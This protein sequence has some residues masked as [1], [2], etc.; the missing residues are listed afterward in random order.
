MFKKV[1]ILSLFCFPLFSE[2]LVTENFKDRIRV[3]YLSSKLPFHNYLQIDFFERQTNLRFIYL[4]NSSPGKVLE[5]ETSQITDGILW[6]NSPYPEEKRIKYLKE[7]LERKNFDFIILEN[8]RFNEDIE[9]LIVDY[10]KDGGRLIWLGS[11]YVKD[12]YLSQLCPYEEAKLER[13]K[14]DIKVVNKNPIIIGIPV[15]KIFQKINFSPSKFKKNVN[16][17]ILTAPSG[18]GV[19]GEMEFGKGKIVVLNIPSIIPPDHKLKYQDFDTEF[20][21]CKFW[22]QIGKFLKYKNVYPYPVQVEIVKTE[23]KEILAGEDIFLKIKFYEYEKNFSGFFVLS[24]IDYKNSTYYKKEFQIKEVKDFNFKVPE[25]IESGIYYLKGEILNRK[26]EKVFEAYNLLNV[27][28]NVKV[29]V[30]TDKY[31]YEIGEEV[32]IKTN[33]TSIIKPE[34]YKLQIV[35]Y[36]AMDIPVYFQEK[37]ILN[38]E[39]NY[40]FKWKMP[41]YGVD[42]WN[43]NICAFVK[44]EN[45]D[46]LAS[47]IK[48]FWRYKK[49][50]MRE[51]FLFSNYWAWQDVVPSSMMKLFALYH[52]GIGFNGG[53]AWREPYYSYFNMRAW[54][55]FPT[56]LLENFTGN[57]TKTDFSHVEEWAKKDYEHFLHTSAYVIYDFGEESGFYYHWSNNP[58]GRKWIKDED[59]PEGAHKLFQYYLKEK[60]KTIEKLNE[61]WETNFKSFEEVKLKRKYGLPS[62]WLFMPLKEIERNIAPYIDT[63]GFFF[64]YN[65][66]VAENITRNINKYNPTADWSLSFQLTFNLYSPIPMTFIHPVYHSTI[67][68]PW[69]ARAIQN[70]LNK[71]TPFFSFHWGFDEIYPVWGQFWNHNLA[72]LSTFQCNWGE[73]FNYNLTHSRSTILFKNYVK[74][75]REREKFFLNCYPVYDY[76]IGIYHPM[77]DWCQVYSRPEF[78][79][80]SQG[81]DSE[82]M[83]QLGYKSTGAGFLGGPEFQIYNVLSSSGY[84]PVFVSDEEILKCKIILIPYCELISKEAIKQ[85]KEF[86]SNGGIL[87]TF[88]VIGKYDEYGKPYNKIPGG[89]LDEIIGLEL[90]DG[91]IGQRTVITLPSKIEL[92]DKIYY[93]DYT[94]RPGSEPPYLWIFAHQNVKNIYNDTKVITKIY[95]GNPFLTVHQYGKG[96]A[97]HINGFTFDHFMQYEF[98]H[99][100]NESLRQFLTS[101]IRVIGN[102]NPEI[103]V[104]RPLYY[105]EG[106]PELV[107]YQYKLEQSDI[108]VLSIYS[109]R[110]NQEITGEVIV[111]IPCEE[112]IDIL[113]GESISLSRFKYKK[114]VKLKDPFSFEEKETYVS[115]EGWSFP[116]K[117]S[118]GDVAFYA[119]IPY[120][121]GEINLKLNSSKIVV[122]KDKISI[123]IEI[124][125]KDK[126]P[127]PD[128]HPVH[129]DVFDSSGN[130]MPML[131]RKITCTS[132]EKIEIQTRLGDPSGKWKIRVRDCLNGKED[133]KEVVAISQNNRDIPKSKEIFSSLCPIKKI[134]ISDEEF[135]SLL[136]ALKNL[137]LCKN[138][139]K[140]DLSFYVMEKDA[141]RNR[142]FQLL[143]QVNWL[144]KENVLKEYLKRGG[145]IILTGEDLGYECESGIYLDPINLK[146]Y[147]EG[148]DFSV[149]PGLKP[150]GGPNKLET[151]EKIL[152]QKIKIPLKVRIVKKIGKG[153]II[154]DPISFDNLTQLSGSLY[155]YFHNKWLEDLNSCSEFKE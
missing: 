99:F 60:Y 111:N 134:D 53:H 38:K 119:L 131:S 107:Y 112:V 66:Q 67:L 90:E 27:K 93:L 62:G 75:V 105:G 50:T 47:D 24:L 34:N 58:F 154:L 121:T 118:P 25:N 48:W 136:N 144:E 33:I 68:K 45:N 17:I 1:I 96:L 100:Q 51:K 140:E 150:L 85:L 36:D 46:L 153:K 21:L 10:V 155:N 5:S 106:I 26:R 89:G 110:T 133:I 6:D 20:L 42:G 49:W 63:H 94:E 101:I 11:D 83:G 141:S 15:E 86:V 3:L 128:A 124:C 145:T 65:K 44:N 103:F 28:G 39:E 30:K 147:E 114:K 116:V 137:Y 37:N 70:S 31:G 84:N 43:F 2:V 52:K 98:S 113:K 35:I 72:C 82:I 151:L 139:S 14:E 142:I 123:E 97:I 8:K 104:I 71:N 152:N 22:E 12:G 54:Y 129:I 23:E 132:H 117:L 88:P 148:V 41:D 91:I 79:L 9:K 126:T 61:E 59:I 109:D 40:E 87:I 149:C 143:N 115:K 122:G 57:F 127:I 18:Y 13:K 130:K 102:I 76:S 32:N 64:W 69:N 16:P 7:I 19:L 56:T 74:K 55:Q 146:T 95:D 4:R 135:I 108:R 78:F 120:K 73:M 81:P 77:S 138:L 80:K 125:K 92:G 29:E